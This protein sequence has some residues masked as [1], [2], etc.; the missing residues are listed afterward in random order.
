MVLTRDF[1]EDAVAVVFFEKNYEL[2]LNNVAKA[3][4]TPCENTPG[5]SYAGFLIQR[6]SRPRKILVANEAHVVHILQ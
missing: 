4:K 3:C 5:I 2:M 6:P 1:V